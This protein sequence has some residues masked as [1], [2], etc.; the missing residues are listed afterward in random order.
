MTGLPPRLRLA[1]RCAAGIPGG[2]RR[3]LQPL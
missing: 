1:G 3:T 2:E